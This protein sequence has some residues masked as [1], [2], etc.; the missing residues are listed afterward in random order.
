MNINDLLYSDVNLTD[1]DTYW[2]IE[3]FGHPT[4]KKYLQVVG[5]NDLAELATLSTTVD[6]VEL[7]RKHSLVQG[8]L[9]T[10][11]ALLSI[12]NTKES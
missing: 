7:S 5:R 8:K 12:T 6:A 2:I 9:S 10:I 11:V 4:M 1:A 3:T